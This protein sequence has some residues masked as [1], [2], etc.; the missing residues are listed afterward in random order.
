[1]PEDRCPFAAAVD[2]QLPAM[3]GSMMHGALSGDL[4]PR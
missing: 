2:E 4:T 1:V 3:G